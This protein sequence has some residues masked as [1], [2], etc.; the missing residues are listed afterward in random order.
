M[1]DRS[2]VSQLKYVLTAVIFMILAIVSY[3]VIVS[4][5]PQ[6]DPLIVVG[7]LLASLGTQWWAVMGYMKAEDGR[8]QS[9]QTYHQVNGRLDDFKRESE[10]RTVRLVKEAYIEGLRAAHVSVVIPSVVASQQPP[11]GA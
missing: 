2:P 5:R 10:E 7:G 6:W 9:R 1:S 3:M 8:A 4:L 11:S